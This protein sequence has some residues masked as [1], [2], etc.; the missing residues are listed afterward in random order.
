MGM[1]KR[2]LGSISGGR[3]SVM[4]MKLLIDIKKLKPF[5]VWLGGF[6]LYT[7][8]INDSE[9]YVFVFANTSREKKETLVFMN[10]TEKYWGLK[11][12]WIEAVVNPRAN[13]GTSYKV[14]NFDTAKRDGSV[15]EAVIAKYGIP[16]QNFPHCTREMKQYAIRAFMRYIGWGSWEDYKTIIGYRADEPKRNSILK[17]EKLNQWY[18]LKEWN[19]LKPDVAYFW[20]RQPFDLGLIDADGNCDKCWK[21]SDLKIIY[22]CKTTP[23]DTWV[24]EMESKYEKFE[25]GR[26]GIN[27]PYRFFRHNRT[28]EEV[29]NDYPELKNKTAQEIEEMLN[30]KSLVEEGSNYDLIEQDDCAESCEP[31]TELE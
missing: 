24:K 11:V 2:F 31:F 26:S 23:H 16:D 28:L 10:N 8:Y 7:K 9:E 17:A 4:M 21:K 1:K 5:E 14:V 3:S 25:A 20:N 27:A 12:T 29:I 30:D 15:F 19:I 13:Q 6:Y 22:Q 18:P